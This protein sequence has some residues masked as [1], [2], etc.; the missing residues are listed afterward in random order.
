MD[1]QKYLSVVKGFNSH[2]FGSDLFEIDHHHLLPF[3][4]SMHPWRFSLHFFKQVVF[5]NGLAFKKQF[6]ELK[7]FAEGV[8]SDVF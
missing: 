1:R 3:V 7:D 8:N 6:F 4:E 5:L 2:I